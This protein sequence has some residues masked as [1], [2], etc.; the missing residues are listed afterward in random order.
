ML[1]R[2][3]R[4]HFQGQHPGE[5][6]QEIIHRHWF[7]IFLHLFVVIALGVLLV[8]SFLILPLVFPDLKDEIALRFSYFLQNTLFIFLWIY[9]FLIW[10]DYYFDVWVITNERIVNI[11]QKGLFAR[12]VSELKF[13]NVQDVTSTVEGLLPTVLNYGDVYVQTAGE[14]ERFVFRMVPDPYAVKDKIMRLSQK[15]T[16]DNL[17]RMAGAIRQATSA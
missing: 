14:K 17:H 1:S 3:E 12:E 16:D 9:G 10:I 6:V 5:E 8:G 13:S 7:N 11:E 15:A 4:C 2:H